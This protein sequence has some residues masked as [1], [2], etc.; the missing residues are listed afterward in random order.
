MPPFDRPAGRSGGGDAS[1]H[2]GRHAEVLINHGGVRARAPLKASGDSKVALDRDGVV[3]HRRLRVE[4][5]G[6]KRRL[7]AHQAIAQRRPCIVDVALK[8]P[9]VLGRP[10]FGAW[11]QRAFQ[12]HEAH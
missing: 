2:A 3:E 10:G 4:K 8:V 7:P 1:V 12:N 6:G 9:A 5:V 11:P